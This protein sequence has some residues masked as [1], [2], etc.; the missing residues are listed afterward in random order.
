MAT[1][2]KCPCSACGTNIEFPAEYAG[3]EVY[4]PSCNSPT[5][6]ATPQSEFSS[7]NLKLP[8]PSTTKKTQHHRQPQQDSTTTTDWADWQFM[9]PL[10][11][12]AS[13]G[14]LFKNVLPLA[15]AALGFM[16]G[17]AMFISWIKWWGELASKSGL[18]FA[19]GISDQLLIAVCVYMIIHTIC[20]CA[21][22]LANLDHSDFI[23]FRTISIL[24]RTTGEILACVTVFGFVR[25]GANVFIGCCACFE[26]NTEFIKSYLTIIFGLSDQLDSFSPF[27]IVILSFFIALAMFLAG[28]FSA[29]VW[30][31]FF[32][33]AAEMVVMVVVVVDIAK[34]TKSLLDMVKDRRKS[35]Y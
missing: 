1:I 30:L 9:E 24:L 27:W 25:L 14:I 31:A 10:R 8:P 19:L 34:N 20:H 2:H 22:D 29:L 33:L 16:L 21:D 6:L 17:I 15:L 28:I 35:L 23:V 26:G 13:S 7:A 5:T 11:G 12:L 4:C 32:Y 18:L 3:N